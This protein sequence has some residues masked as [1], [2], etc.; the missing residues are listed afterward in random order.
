MATIDVTDPAREVRNQA[1]P[2]RAGQPVR[3]RPR[4]A[5]R[6]SSARAAAG[7]STARAR[8]A[9]SPGSVEAREHGRRAE[10]NL[11]VLRTHDRY[12]NRI[13]EVELDPSWHWLLRGAIEREIHALPWR[14]QQ[15]GAHVVRAALFTLWGNANDGVMCPVSMTY[16][17]IPALRDGAPELAA[18]WEPRLTQARLRV[19]RARGDGDDRAPGRLRR[20]RQHHPRRA[21]RTTVCTSSTATSG[22]APIRRATCSWCWRRRPAGCRASWSSAGRRDGVPAAEG[23]ARD[24]LAALVRG[25]VPRRPRPARRRGGSRR[26]GDHQDGQPH[27]A[28]LPA[29]RD[30]RAA[31]RHARGDPSRPPSL[32]VRRAARRSAGDAQRARRP[33]DRV[34]GRDRRRDA[35][36]AQLRR[37]LGGGVPPVRD[38]G[39]EVLGL[40]ARPGPRRR[41]ARV[42]GRQRVRRGLRDAAAVPRRAAELDL[43]GLGQRR[44]ARRAA[45][46]GQGAGGAA[47]VPGR[48]RAGGRRRPAP[49]R[50]PGARARAGRRRCSRRAAIRSSRR[51]GSS[52]SW[53]SRCRARCWFATRR[54][55][56]RMRSAPR[57]SAARAGACT[58]R[59]RA[60]STRRRSSTARCRHERRRITRRA[61]RGRAAV[62]A[63]DEPFGDHGR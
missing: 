15:P 54:R 58:A 44:G 59:S 42:P 62:R 31:P 18:E 52:R 47:G 26:A 39:D 51:G 43:G 46:D 14:G 21:G 20:P 61:N 60:G 10:R 30:H 35:G 5:A 6:R 19:G 13:D 2:L 17:A 27:P 11:P 56:W 7:E 40:Q 1:P 63:R 28:R 49:R 23:Q 37:G 8:P 57:G 22:S 38:R 45:R 12:G 34:R 3:G 33:G 16:A 36:R 32:R 24:A 41:G 9:R 25:R 50:A 48:V 29:R 53:R 55:R 4:A